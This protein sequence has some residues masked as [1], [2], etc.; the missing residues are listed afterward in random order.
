LSSTSCEAPFIPLCYFC[1]SKRL[2]LLLLLLLTTPF[3][4]YSWEALVINELSGI[5]LFLSAPGVS[6]SLPVKGEV[7]LQIIGVNNDLFVADIAVLAAI[8]ALCCVFVVFVLGWRNRQRK[9]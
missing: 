6:L 5:D 4:R 8:Y 9:P 2:L 3:L 7:F 1:S